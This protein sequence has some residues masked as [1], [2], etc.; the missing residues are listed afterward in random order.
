MLKMYKKVFSFCDS[1][2]RLVK[3]DVKIMAVSFT[4][5]TK[6]LTILQQQKDLLNRNINPFQSFNRSGIYI[7]VFYK[8]VDL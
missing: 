1:H 8:L 5:E 3:Y 4:K 2:V 7:T 6:R